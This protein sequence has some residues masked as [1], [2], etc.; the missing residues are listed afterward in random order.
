VVEH[1]G[2]AGLGPDGG[3]NPLDGGGSV[4]TAHGAE[5]ITTHRLFDGDRERAFADGCAPL[6][7]TAVAGR[8]TNLIAA[9]RASYYLNL[10]YA[11][12]LLR[13]DHELEPR[14]IDLYRR[15]L[16]P[17]RLL[18]GD[19]SPAEFAQD[20]EQLVDWGAVDRI[21][22]AQRLRGYKDNRRVRFRYRLTDDAVALLEWLE[23]RLAAKLEGRVRD[24]RDRLADVVAYLKEARRVLDGWRRPEGGSS[25]PDDARRA[26]YL[27]EAIGDAVGEISDELLSFRAEMIGFAHRPYDLVALREILEWLDR[28]V[29]LYLGRVEQ[30]RGEIRD[31]LAALSAPRYR[32]AAAECRAALD[33]ERTATP[34]AFRQ[35]G[36]LREPGELLDAA[37][38][39]FRH[40]GRLAELCRYI[41]ESAR[42]VLVKMH[43]HV[44]ELERRNARLDD[45]RAAIAAVARLG[46]EADVAPLVNRL[47]ASAHG[48]FDRRPGFADHRVA[49][50]VPRRHA[51]SPQHRVKASP[52]RGK[53]GSPEDAR[54]LR[55]KRLGELRSWLVDAVFGEADRV[56]LSAIETWPPEAPRR[57]LDVARARHLGDGADAR[58]RLEVVFEAAEGTAT[59]TSGAEHL[60]AP[61]CIVRGLSRRGSRPLPYGTSCRTPKGQP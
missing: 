11:L 35:S 26:Y 44:K 59:I 13:R 31:R 53:R 22:E 37:G 2:E 23:A 7:A 8:V 45:V 56:R 43:H 1:A 55:A 17:Q 29:V 51:A 15:V 40:R 61:D 33:A 32:R 12:L 28:Y 57:W 52:L 54:A 36:A 46:S 48:R 34:R 27:L 16:G 30:L 41:D 3:A 60:E 39:F 58:R 10:V 5:P 19:Y 47:V 42:A 24:S 18:G 9:E 4:R 14:H 38:R 25:E 50:P 49:P 20:L 6:L 21:T